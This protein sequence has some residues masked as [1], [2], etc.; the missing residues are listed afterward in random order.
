MRPLQTSQGVSVQAVYS[1]CRMIRKIIKDFNV[2]HIVI[3]WDS[4][5]K[6]IRHEIFPEYKATRQS[7]PLD[8]FEQKEL[9]LQFIDEIGMAQLSQ[10]GIEADDLIASLAKKFNDQGCQIMIVSGD[11]DLAQ[12]V[13]NGSIS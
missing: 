2:E 10:V 7:A 12:I 6:N 3:V 1:F 5:G 9:I 8:L 4:K 11:K 13:T